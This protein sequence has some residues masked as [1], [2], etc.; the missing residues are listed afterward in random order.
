MT[1]NDIWRVIHQKVQEDLWHVLEE[2]PGLAAAVAEN[3]DVRRYFIESEQE[4]GTDFLTGLGSRRGFEK[5]FA[6]ELYTDMR[7]AR[8]YPVALALI[9]M[10]DFRGLNEELGH[11]GA[12]L[13]LK[14]L[15]ASIKESVR[16]SDSAYRYGGDE[17]ALVLPNTTSDGAVSPIVKIRERSRQ[18]LNQY[19]S[20]MSFGI[21]H[22]TPE[23]SRDRE[24]VSRHK[25]NEIKEQLLGNADRAL[26][27]IK[28]SGQKGRICVYREGNF[29]ILD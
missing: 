14:R 6:R 26:Y 8:P 12:D 18:A 17:F 10:D 22:Y 21:A 25:I 23:N 11:P 3:P 29:D 2:N 15:G 20:S 9:D 4:K 7:L 1:E 27:T 24:V 5:D 13:V 19:G 16:V 28:E